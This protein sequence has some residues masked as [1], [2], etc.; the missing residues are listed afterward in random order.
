MRSIKIIPLLLS[1]LFFPSICFSFN[2]IDIPDYRPFQK[3]A[4]IKTRGKKLYFDGE[5]TPRSVSKVMALLQK[6][7]ITTISLNSMGGDVESAIRLGIEIYN[8]NIS[9]EVRTVCASAC[10]NYLFVAGKHKFL[11]KNSFILWHG[12]T[13]GPKNEMTIQGDISREAFFKLESVKRIQRYE[14]YF[15]KKIKVNEKT[16]YCPQLKPNYHKDYPEKWFSYTPLDMAKLGVK[17]V[18]F[19]VRADQWI[20]H[21]EK[22]HVIF[23]KYCN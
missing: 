18:I 7:Q 16:P 23:A 8:R 10:A 17:D 20:S 5:I 14:K 2:G 11:S 4:D 1:L 15:Y 9:I 6:N 13:N 19:E 3:V 22:N 21:A 12:S